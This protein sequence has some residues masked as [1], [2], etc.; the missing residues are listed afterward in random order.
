MT[1]LPAAPALIALADATDPALCGG[2]A[3]ALARLRGA[4]LSV[5]DGVVIP[6]SLSEDAFPDAATAILSWA[7]GRAPYGLIAR[8]SASHEDGRQASFAGL[9]VSVFTP[10]DSTPLLRALHRVRDSVHAPAA[11]TYALGRGVAHSTSMAVLVQPA[12]RP[13]ASGVLAAD[14]TGR[15]R[16]RIEA[17]RGLAHPLVSGRQTG[18]IHTGGSH[19]DVVFIPCDQATVALP[20]SAEE[21]RLPPGEWTVLRDA[22]GTAHRVKVRLS[23]DG[24]LQLHPPAAWASRLILTAQQVKDLLTTGGIS[25]EVLGWERIDIEW[26]LTFDGLHLLQARPLTA[27]LPPPALGL[28]V[29][30]GKNQWRGIPAVPGIGSGPA[31]HLDVATVEALAPDDIAGAVI[32]CDALG[33]EAVPVLH[34]APS[35]IVSGTGGPLSHTAILAREFGIP[36][37][38]AV[39][40]A[41]TAIP[42]GTHIQVDGTV[43]TVAT[44]LTAT[45]AQAVE[46]VDLSGSAVLVA[47]PPVD[48]PTDGRAATLVLFDPAT[49]DPSDLAVQRGAGAAPV[50][51]LQLTADP[52]FPHLPKG[53]RDVVVPG[54]GRLAW[55][56]REP[57]PAR[58]VVLAPDG[59]VLFTRDTG[60]SPAPPGRTDSSCRE[61]AS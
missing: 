24:V 12:V 35:A 29:D 17:V 15:T 46:N 50:G 9:H 31:L 25:A 18:E 47:A 48:P 42:S 26:A 33:S 1:T 13:Y 19:D 43:G 27:P 20:G 41:V 44:V 34:H 4:G 11:A 39:A 49:T 30:T 3:A 54:M 38:T 5:P 37:V 23:D 6:A 51:L 14:F 8:S 21:L 58:V 52:P 16:W 22:D 36:C 59:T 60:L 40:N 7:A 45:A 32:V 61:I 28:I 56:R 2:K 57:Q 10:A 53:Y 55:P